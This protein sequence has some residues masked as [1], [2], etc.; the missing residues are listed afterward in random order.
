MCVILLVEFF[1]RVGLR[2][3]VLPARSFGVGR[4]VLR[5]AAAT[6]RIAL[7]DIDA[8]GGPEGHDVPGGIVTGT[9]HVRGEGR[10]IL[11]VPDAI[12]SDDRGALYEAPCSAVAG[13]LLH[14]Q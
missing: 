8:V 3:R 4:R 5:L 6:R 9:G 12:Y 14:L 10:F 7:L 2:G 11:L 13:G 1:G